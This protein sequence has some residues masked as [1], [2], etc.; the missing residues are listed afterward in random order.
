MASMR[1]LPIILVFLMLGVSVAQAEDRK[2]Q[3]ATWFRQLADREPGVRES[4]RR[5]LMGIDASELPLLREIVAGAAASLKPAQ[6]DP[7]Q[8]IVLQVKT[9]EAI[10][11]LPRLDSGFLGV[12]LPPMAMEDDDATPTGVPI[13]SRLRGFVAYRLLENGDVILAIG[14]GDAMRDTFT[15]TQ[16]RQIVGSLRAGDEVSVR[17]LRGSRQVTFKF[18][19]DA[20]PITEGPERVQELVNEAEQDAGKYWDKDFAPLVG[21]QET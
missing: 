19:L 6:I 17:V 8:D 14:P 4:A 5:E 11:K 13:I 1:R 20:P 12:S 21:T 15:P 18:R 7:L 10:L 9:R 3:I 2:A 16:L